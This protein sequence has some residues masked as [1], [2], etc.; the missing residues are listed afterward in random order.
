[1]AEKDKAM[2]NESKP[3]VRH[4]SDIAPQ[5]TPRTEKE[6]DGLFPTYCFMCNS[7]A[8]DVIKVR[9][10]NGIPVNLEPNYDLSYLTPFKERGW[11]PCSMAMQMIHRH[12]NPHRVKAPMKRTNPKKGREED[13]GFV[14]IGWDEALDLFAEKLLEVK[15]KGWFDDNGYYRIAACEG[16][17][18]TCPSFNGTYPVLFGGNS[19]CIGFPFGIFPA[20]YSLGHGGGTK[21]YHT[22]HI[23]GEL[24]NKAFTTGT[25]QP[26]CNL[27]LSFGKSEMVASGTH[28]AVRTADARVRGMKRIQVEPVLTTTGAVAN[29]WVPIKPGTDAAFLYAMIHHVL[30]ELDWRAACDID[31]LKQITNNPYLVSPNGYYIRDPETKKALIWDPVDNKA[32]VWDAEGI[33]DFA[34]DGEYTVSGVSI[35]PDEEAEYFTDVKVK[36]VFQHLIEHVRNNTPE[37]ASEICDVSAQTIRRI[38]DDMVKTADAASNRRINM[39]GW[40]MPLRPVCIQLGKGVNAGRGSVPAVW[41]SST[42]LTLLGAFEVPGGLVGARIHYSGPAEPKTNDGFARYPFNPTSKEDYRQ[43]TGRRDC[44][45]GLCPMTATFYG[46]LHMA[47]VNIVNGFPN[48]PKASPPDVFITYKSNLPISQ[49]DT[50]IVEEVL[51]IIPFMVS[52]VHTLDE[53]AWY[54]DL[55][56]PE[57]CDFESLQLFPTGGVKDHDVYWEQAGV[58]IKQPIVKRLYNTMNMTDIMT[59]I[60]NRTGMLAE[61]NAFINRGDWLCFELGGTPYELD[62]NTKYN[63]EEIYDRAARATS[64]KFSGGKASFSLE[65]LKQTGGFFGPLPQDDIYP[66][67]KAPGMQIRPW[68]MYPL[69][70]K[71]RMR[72]EL[73]YQERLKKIHQELSRRLHERNIFWWDEQ[74]NE[75]DFLPPCEIVGDIWDKVIPEIYGKKAEDYPFW[76]LSTRSGQQP[77]GL[78]M[79]LPQVHELT[80]LVMGHNALQMN[81]KAAE[82]LGIKEGDEIWL[83]SPYRKIKGKVILRQGIRPDVVLITQMYGHWKMPVAKDLGIPNPNEIE[84]SLLETLSIGGS[85]NDKIKVKV[86]KA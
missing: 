13:P 81:K 72:F 62:L 10:K 28:A 15:N 68:F 36:P 43:I 49:H 52:F 22:E 80:R 5:P 73:P 32:K 76:V 14:E 45:T 24:W 18:G 61:Y 6:K 78:T 40:E 17:D 57:D 69:Y 50:P 44:G 30:H 21:C 29:E 34:L 66:A 12:F 38:A 9:V 67:G 19:T 64:E 55:L 8:P 86:Y 41:G 25:D 7:G 63:A 35:G 58:A 54:A 20:D 1:M 77:W 71:K 42:F 59:E 84:P 60:A 82:S 53:T 83:E 33:K 39:F 11:R 47:Y 75:T 70:K 2:K 79:S 3:K 56:L 46:P 37:W 65:D 4:A 27:V 85:V 48:W 51:K 16:S 23:F 26:R 74:I 31:Y